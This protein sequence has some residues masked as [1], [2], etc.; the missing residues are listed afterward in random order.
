[1][2]K[3]H[4]GVVHHYRQCLGTTI[5]N[6]VVTILSRLQSTAKHLKEDMDTSKAMR[7][8]N[9]EAKQLQQEAHKHKNVY[10]E[11]ALGALPLPWG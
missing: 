4:Q 6:P 10:Q 2:P 9:L 3:E 8:A 5:Y 11:G 1:M 7:W